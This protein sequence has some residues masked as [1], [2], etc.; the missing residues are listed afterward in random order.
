[1]PNARPVALVTGASRG[2]GKA[3]AIDLAKAG[4]DVAVSARTLHEGEG[5][6]SDGTKL[7]GSLDTTVAAIEEAAAT[8]FLDRRYGRVERARQLGPIAVATLPLVQGA[9]GDGDVVAGLRQ[10]YRRGLPD[11]ARGSRDKC[12]RPSI[13]H[14][15]NLH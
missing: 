7:P 11:P 5:R 14:G 12:N 6:Y 15:G 3:A 4:Y 1:M 9:G 2:I 8:G 13:R 10:V